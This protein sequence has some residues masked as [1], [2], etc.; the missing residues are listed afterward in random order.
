MLWNLYVQLYVNTSSDSWLCWSPNLCQLAVS[1][2][3]YA[4]FGQLVAIL[5]ARSGF[6]DLFYFMILLN[7]LIRYLWGKNSY[8]LLICIVDVRQ[9]IRVHNVLNDTEIDVSTIIITVFYFSLSAHKAICM[10]ALEL[11]SFLE[12]SIDACNY[13]T[14]PDWLYLY[15]DMR[16]ASWLVDA[17][18]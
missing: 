18:Q 10:L 8:L 16:T 4:L 9:V 11:S 7:E 17:I 2:C 15:S 5:C 1:Y 14:Q 13:S 12:I 3:S 6:I